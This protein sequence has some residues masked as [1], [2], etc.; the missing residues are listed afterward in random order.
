M[1]LPRSL[2]ESLKNVSI[3][4]TEIVH[5][6][7]G[8]QCLGLENTDTIVTLLSCGCVVLTAAGEIRSV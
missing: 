7:Q 5:G 8:I 2:L 4:Q 3:D 6:I 1:L